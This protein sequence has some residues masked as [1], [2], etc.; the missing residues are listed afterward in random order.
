MQNRIVS[1]VVSGDRLLSACVVGRQKERQQQPM[2]IIWPSRSRWRPLTGSACSSPCLIFAAQT[3]AVTCAKPKIPY[4]KPKKP[5]KLM[6]MAASTYLSH[7]C[8]TSFA[9]SCRSLF[10]KFHQQCRCD[11]HGHS[12]NWLLNFFRS[13]PVKNEPCVQVSSLFWSKFFGPSYWSSFLFKLISV[14]IIPFR[15]KTWLEAPP[16][17]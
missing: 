3:T 12:W 4:L 1:T 8:F 7:S 5:F 10:C 13:F 14:L 9:L 15:W 6:V 2:T 17:S 11:L 16:D